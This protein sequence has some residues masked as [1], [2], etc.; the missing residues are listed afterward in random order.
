MIVLG[1]NRPKPCHVRMVDGKAVET[2]YTVSPVPPVVKW[3]SYGSGVVY[4]PHR[5]MTAQSRRYK[6][7]QVERVA[8]ELRETSTAGSKLIRNGR[9]VS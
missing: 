8:R 4:E 9:V 5:P 2:R 6:R 7:L 3:K 1:L